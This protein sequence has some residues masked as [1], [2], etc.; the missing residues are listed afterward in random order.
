MAPRGTAPAGAV[1][2]RGGLVWPGFVD[3]HTHLDKGHIWPRSPNPDGSFLGAAGTTSSDR[4]TRWTAEDVRR[5]MEFGLRMRL[6]AR[7]GRRPHAPRFAWRPRPRSRGRS[8]RRCAMPGPDGSSC[9]RTSL[10]PMDAFAE[11]QGDRLADIVAEAGGI[12]GCVHPPERRRPRCAAAG[13]PRAARAHLPAGDAIAA[14]TWTCMSTKAA[15]W[16]P[17]R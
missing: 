3:V 5:R 2:L 13:V 15:I 7:H 8:S 16:A 6:G 4:S 10:M 14:S 1:D 12:L 11:P 17:R 9:R